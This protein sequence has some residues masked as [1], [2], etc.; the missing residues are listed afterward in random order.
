[1]PCEFCCDEERRDEVMD[2]V[3]I[4]KTLL[5]QAE[6]LLE[7]QQ[8]NVSIYANIAALLKTSLPYASWAGFYLF[9]GTSLFLGP[10]Q[11]NV[12]CVDITL[13][14]GVCGLSAREKRVVIVP[15][16]HA[17]EGHIACD[18]GS[19]SEIVVPLMKNDKLLAVLDL[20]SYQFASF[21]DVDADFLTQLAQKMA[22]VLK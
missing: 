16:V 15:D 8:E 10:F 4:Y 14:R 3:S 21:D 19:N 13:D 17:F 9:N 12:A 18:S 1:M 22:N 11:G 5:I 7:G 6:G 2:K 20:D